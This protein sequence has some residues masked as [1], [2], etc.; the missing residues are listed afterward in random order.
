MNNTTK[1]TLSNNS[2]GSAGSH[3]SFHSFSATPESNSPQQYLGT[4][5]QPSPTISA[6]RLKI[7]QSISGADHDS[8]FA[9]CLPDTTQL[10]PVTRLQHIQSQ[11]PRTPNSCI[12]GVDTENNT[13]NNLC[14]D[15]LPME[16]ARALSAEV[17]GLSLT[18]D[19]VS[20][21]PYDTLSPS[22]K[23]IL[24]NDAS[25]SALP[26]LSLKCS[27]DNSINNSTSAGV[28][29]VDGKIHHSSETTP[30][31]ELMKST[32][33]MSVEESC[34]VNNI[35]MLCVLLE[36]E[37]KA[38][39]DAIFDECDAVEDEDESKCT[40]NEIL[41]VIKKSSSSDSSSCDI[42]LQTEYD[43]LLE[44]GYEKLNVLTT[45]LQGCVFKANNLNLLSN[46]NKEFSAD[47]I[48]RNQKNI[49]FKDGNND[50]NSPTMVV[51]KR[52]N[53]ELYAHG[54]TIQDG[55]Q[56]SVDEDIVKE[57]KL[58]KYFQTLSPPSA[59]VLYYTQY[60]FL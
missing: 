50:S 54:I 52:T 10:P 25:S 14:T 18:N 7:D 33:N 37:E 15:E 57:M 38:A 9:L 48:Y 51:I 49:R 46:M 60:S 4:P 11:T 13:H 19:D 34:S 42:H 24:F 23:T 20:F 40:E 21:K 17:I 1:L 59:L 32:M 35:E 28:N 56:Y 6:S 12:N 26:I 27:I 30:I 16:R 39:M 2:S 22:L 8:V 36:N 29:D 3:N 47:E 31:H 5:V 45:T 41:E 44:H 55:K 53:K 43:F 58:M